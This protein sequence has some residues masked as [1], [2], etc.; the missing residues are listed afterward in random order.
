MKGF[1]KENMSEQLVVTLGKYL[2]DPNNT[3]MLSQQKVTAA[4]PEVWSMLCWAKAMRK[5]YYINKEV[6]PKKEALAIAEE[7]VKVLSQELSVKQAALKKAQDEVKT[8]NDDLNRT[9]ANKERLEKDY[10]DKTVQLERAKQLIENL[11]GEKDRW[12]ELAAQLK[13]DYINLTGDV[14]VSSGMIAYLGA[15]TPS[16]RNDITSDWIQ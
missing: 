5:F 2:D 1:E 11:G 12:K 10:D 3:E 7:K 13:I 8:L 16:Y 15:F 14:L 6:L 9:I 4:S